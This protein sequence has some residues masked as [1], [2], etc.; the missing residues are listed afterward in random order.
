MLKKQIAFLSIYFISSSMALAYTPSIESLFRNGNNGEIAGNT[1]VADFIVKKKKSVISELSVEE[2]SVESEEVSKIIDD[3]LATRFLIYNENEKYPKLIQA[4]YKGGSVSSNLM[5]RYSTHP[6]YDLNKIIPVKEN[7]EARVFYSLMSSLLN[8]DGSLLMTLLTELDP[9][10]KTNKMLVN[11][12]QLSIIKS[13]KEYLLE[14]KAAK[15]AKDETLLVMENP[16]KPE[17]LEKKAEVKKIM[18]S[19]FLMDSDT[20]VRTRDGKQFFWDIN[21]DNIQARFDTNHYLKELKFITALGNI[22]ILCGK[23]IKF[24]SDLIF[25]EYIIFKDLAGNEFEITMKKLRLIKDSPEN[26]SKRLKKYDGFIED[27]K[28]SEP[29]VKPSFLL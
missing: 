2:G 5:E 9:E 12:D 19:P 7:I 14:A 15:I 6:Y 13:Y 25:P 23:F 29:V 20:V 28:I 18:R 21:K 26:H 22:E 1:V 11:K 4:D 24:R 8:N 16:L 17:D 27:N 10:I 3:T